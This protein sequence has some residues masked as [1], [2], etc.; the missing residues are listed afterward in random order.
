MWQ[1]PLGVTGVTT[2]ITVYIDEDISSDP[3]DG[4]NSRTWYDGI[5]YK[6]VVPEE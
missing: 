5:G 6:A 2:R 1:A 3:A 4:G